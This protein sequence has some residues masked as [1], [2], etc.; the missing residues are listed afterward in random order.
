M[1]YEIVTLE[2]K[3]AVGISA[4]TN[5]A[6]PDMGAVIGGLWNRFYNEGIYAAIPK[7]ADAKAL[8]FTPT[9][10]GM[11]RQITPHSSPVRPPISP[12][13]MNLPSVI[14]RVAVTRNSWYT[15]VWCRRSPRRGRRS[16]R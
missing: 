11:K 15:A 7:K 5:N 2:K 10:P 9:T 16:G 4:R 1:E 13:E 3:T 8:G 14:F 6:S 12:M